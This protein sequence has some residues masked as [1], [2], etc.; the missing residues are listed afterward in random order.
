MKFRI[1]CNYRTKNN[2]MVRTSYIIDLPKWSAAE[3]KSKV[4]SM[5]NSITEVEIFEHQEL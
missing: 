2:A 1:H 4:K 5:N 3:A